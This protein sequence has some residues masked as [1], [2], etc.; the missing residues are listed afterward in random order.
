MRLLRF[1]NQNYDRLRSSCLSK[2]KLF[3]DTVFTADANSLFKSKRLDVEWKRPHE[4]CQNPKLVVDGTTSH[5]VL[6]GQ[7]GNCWFVAASATLAANKANWDR[8]IPDLKEQ[9]RNGKNK[10]AGIY[11]F[12]FWRFGD[13][14][15]VMD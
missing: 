7:L 6:Q 15:E 5:D 1:E 2:N 13:W 9:E 4:L 12:R 3:V 14:I 10:Y 11:K 8:V